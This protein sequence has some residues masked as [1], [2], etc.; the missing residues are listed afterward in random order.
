LLAVS[1]ALDLGLV[2]AAYAFM[3]FDLFCNML[4]L[5]QAPSG[6]WL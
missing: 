3:S 4:L 6:T 1:E 2:D 5:V